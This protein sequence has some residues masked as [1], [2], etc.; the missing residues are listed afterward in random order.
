MGRGRARASK[1][2]LTVAH[3]KLHRCPARHAASGGPQRATAS[4]S[5]KSVAMAKRA[6]FA[7]ASALPFARPTWDLG[8]CGEANEID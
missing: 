6:I 8:A 3:R 5:Y 1:P 2:G 4:A 7:M